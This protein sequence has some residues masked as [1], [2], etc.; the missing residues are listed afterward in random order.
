MA[1]QHAKPYRFSVSQFDRLVDAAVFSSDARVE[2][3]EGQVL[4]VPTGSRRSATCVENV[5]RLLQSALDGTAFVAKHQLLRLSGDT[6]VLPDLVALRTAGDHGDRSRVSAHEALL[7]VEVAEPY[8][9]M[10]REVK[11]RLYASA[12]IP[13]YRVV[14]LAGERVTV[15]GGASAGGYLEQRQY[16]RGEAWE[17]PLLKGQ[18]VAVNSLMVGYDGG[19]H[20]EARR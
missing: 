3:I 18:A 14:D 8:V 4:D 17:S 12:K 2:L 9:E 6:E 13:E 5:E 7:V 16:G 1:L 15:L 10:D 19:W 11:S 20:L